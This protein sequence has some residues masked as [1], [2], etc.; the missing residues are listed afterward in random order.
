MTNKLVRAAL[1]AW[2]L[3]GVAGLA[4]TAAGA[5]AH[6]ADA[7]AAAPKQKAS[8]TVGLALQ[9]AL[10]AAQTKDMATAQAKL[11]EARAAAATDFDKVEVDQVAAFIAINSTP[12]DH[13]GALAAYKSAIANPAFADLDAVEQ[14][15]TMKNAMI[16]CSEIKDFACAVQIGER[17]MA[18]GQIDSAAAGS[19]AVAYYYNKDYAKARA[20]AQK[21]ID[22]A[23]AAG[24]KP[25]QGSLQI[26]LKSYADQK[27]EANARKALEQL[28]LYYG[29]DPGA[30]ADLWDQMIGIAWTP[31]LKDMQILQL[32]RLRYLSAATS[33][34]GDY[35]AGAELAMKNGYPGEARN[36][37]QLGVQRGKG[38]GGSAL[39][40]AR[41]KAAADEKS[42]ASVA[43]ASEKSASGQ[44][45]TI[46]AELFYG[47]GRYAE[48]EAAAR[49]ATSKSG[50][51]DPEEAKMVLGMALTA[52]GKYTD[53]VQAFAQ[54]GGSE[55]Q[56][57]IA[58]V[59][60][61]YAQSHAQAAPA[62][63]K[64]N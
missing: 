3:S 25:D 57:K 36:I 20:L 56:K 43:A 37:L 48:A 52:Q 1:G 44:Q 23:L 19:L 53:A 51:K 22:A 28:T 35:S 21:S 17:M 11:N 6:A 5:P 31:G 29:T 10:A 34:A 61:V 42:L 50:A 59:W 58:H 46:T 30:G 41:N 39:A 38:S 15:S 9:A 45:D 4:V 63:A 2:L 55:G 64:T 18:S 40:D 27:D 12:S 54:V 13:P 60:S 16:L 14:A 32:Y 47:Y 49:R 8:K 62:P 26:M 24:S 7:K 33:E